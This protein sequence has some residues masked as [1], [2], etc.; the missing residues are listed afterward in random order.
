VRYRLNQLRDLFGDE[1]DD[2]AAPFELVVVTR[3]THPARESR[4]W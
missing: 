1:L 2:P 3:R 4:P